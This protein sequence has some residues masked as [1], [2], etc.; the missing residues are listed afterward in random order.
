MRIDISAFIIGLLA[1]IFT[2]VALV[3]AS[4]CADIRLLA[5][6]TRYGDC[7]VEA[8]GEVP[9]GLK[10][11]VVCPFTPDFTTIIKDKR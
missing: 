8:V 11:H 9:G 7:T 4:G 1:A 5:A 10:V 6:Q 3:I 2:Y